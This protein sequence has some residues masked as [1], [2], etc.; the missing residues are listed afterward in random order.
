MLYDLE[1]HAKDRRCGLSRNEDIRRLVGK[2]VEKQT[3][4]VALYN[5]PHRVPYTGRHLIRHSYSIT[6]KRTFVCIMGGLSDERISRA[7]IDRWSLLK[8]NVIILMFVFNSVAPLDQHQPHFEPIARERW[9][10][11]TICVL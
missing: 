8:T 3:L 9:S 1:S 2:L 7:C 6:S 4:D 5:R 11:S 10:D